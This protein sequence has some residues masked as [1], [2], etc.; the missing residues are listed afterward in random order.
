LSDKAIAEQLNMSPH[1]V[2]YH[3]RQLKKKYGAQNRVQLAYMAG[4]MLMT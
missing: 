1:N 4:R 3:L 2:D